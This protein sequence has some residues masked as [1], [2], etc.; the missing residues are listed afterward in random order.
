MSA[1]NPRGEE[2]AGGFVY[3]LAL[4]ASAGLRIVLLLLTIL[5]IPAGRFYIPA[6]DCDSVTC[7]ASQRLRH[8]HVPQSGLAS[9]FVREGRDT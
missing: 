8:I 5:P 3:G 9:E 7:S 2:G 4:R 6:C 1:T